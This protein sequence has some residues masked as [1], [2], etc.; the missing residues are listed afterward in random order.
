ME[1]VAPKEVVAAAEEKCETKMLGAHVD[2]ELYWEFKKEVASR[3]ETMADAIA[4]AAR[5]Y[6]DTP[7]V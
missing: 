2:I 7:T 3:Q 5:M 1:Q 4:H 6:I